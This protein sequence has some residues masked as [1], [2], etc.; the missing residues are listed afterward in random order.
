MYMGTQA[1]G[2]CYGPSGPLKWTLSSIN[3]KNRFWEDTVGRVFHKE[4]KGQ[5]AEIPASP[6][7]GRWRWELQLKV[8][9]GMINGLL[10]F[11]PAHPFIPA[12]SLF[13]S[14]REFVHFIGKVIMKFQAVCHDK[15]GGTRAQS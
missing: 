3:S 4:Q 5:W 11:I 9:T 15:Y 6:S 8:V 7:P 13:F 1:L 10:A 14:P 12:H 2:F